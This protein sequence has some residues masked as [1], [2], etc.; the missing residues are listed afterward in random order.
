MSRKMTRKAK[1]ALNRA[2]FRESRKK[3]GRKSRTTS[4]RSGQ[5]RAS[6]GWQSDFALGRAYG[7]RAPEGMSG[8][9]A[10]R[11]VGREGFKRAKKAAGRR[12][13]YHELMSALSGTKLKAWVCAGPVRS[14][15]G[16]G[17]KRYGGSRQV[18]VLRP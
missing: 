16:G 15:C 5:Q 12:L 8:K 4:S 14:G 2:K 1:R 18:G 13:T 6:I 3:R 7:I 11:Y 17:R 9:K 10:R